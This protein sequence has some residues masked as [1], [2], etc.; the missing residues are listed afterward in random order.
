MGG[1]DLGGLRFATT[2]GND[3][4]SENGEFATFPFSNNK[5]SIT[6]GNENILAIVDTGADINVISKQLLDILPIHLRN[7]FRSQKDKIYC[8]NGS[9]AQVFGKISLPVVISNR[10][11]S[12]Q[13]SVINT[14]MDKVFLGIPF[15]KQYSAQI[16]FNPSNQ[17]T[18]SVHL[19]TPIFSKSFQEI[20]P[21]TEAV[22]QGTLQESLPNSSQGYCYP[23]N[24][25]S[26][27]GYMAAHAAV[28][29]HDDCVPIRVFNSQPYKITINRGERIAS[30]QLFDSDIEL[31]PYENSD[32][33]YDSIN[34]LSNE[35]RVPER[36][37]HTVELN[38]TESKLDESQKQQLQDLVAKYSDCFVNPADGK[39]GLTDLMECKIETVPGT[40]PVCKYPYRLAPHMRDAMGKI[41]KDQVE[42]G[43]I[44]ESTEGAWASPALLVKKSSGDFRLVIDYR[45][46]NA[47]LIPQNLR[48]P[49]IDEVFDTIGENQPQ[50]FSVLDCTQGFHQVPLNTDSRDKTAFIT[51]MGKYRYKT[52]PQ[53]MR[54]A[55]VVFQSLMDLVLRGIQ[56]KYVM[57]YIDDICI[58]SNTFE[59]HLAHLEEVF[60]RLRSANLKLH[61]KKCKFAVQE[62]TYL[63]HVLSPEGIKPNPDKV[64]AIASFPTPTKMKQLRSFLGMIG[65]YRKFI[66]GFGVTA[67]VLYDLT[68]KDVP[69]VWSSECE[70]AFQELKGK[71][72][73]YDV[74]VF[75]NFKKPF[76]LATDASITGLGACLSQEVNGVLRPVGFAGRGLTN[77]ERNYTTTE[78][79]CLAVIWAI[80]HFRVY[81]EGQHFEL[82]TDHNA[83]RFILTNKD[84]R[85]RVARWVTF[86]QQFNYTVKHVKGKNN[87]VP[88]ALSRRDYEFTRTEDDEPIDRYPDLG[89]IHEQSNHNVQKDKLTQVS[90]NPETQ[91]NLYDPKLPIANLCKPGANFGDKDTPV[92]GAIKTKA[93]S[94]VNARREKLR[95]TLTAKA[96][97]N[98]EGIDLS[99]ENIRKE[100]RKDQECRL[101]IKYLTVG[102]LPD[103]DTDARSILLRQEDYIMID[104]ML[105]HIF[106]P[107][108]SKPS[109]QAQLVIPQN[110][111]VHFLKLHHDSELGAHVGNSK[112]L[113][114]MRLKYYWIGMIRDI[115][116]YVLTCPRCQITKSTTGA[117][118]PP[119]QTREVT[120][121]PF[122]TL[123]I[124]TVGPLPKS[125]GY[126]HLVCVTDQY[127]K[128][129]IAW[130]VRDLTATSLIKKFH[131]KIICVYG[132]PRRLVSDNGSA[133]ASS[134]FEELCKLYHI[135][136]SFSTAYHPQSQG[137]VLRGIRNP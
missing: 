132:A 58:F 29:V 53:G 72:L 124:D 108:G 23:T 42:K 44:E 8:A 94:K 16:T 65:Y 117:I 22:I 135:K 123:I 137:S 119:L 69:Y 18:I 85:G 126:E 93:P 106:T 54:N 9:T 116:E 109:A 51:P 121:H 34:S 66:S 67:K 92:W 38:L 48:I 60:T 27:K 25:T 26:G 101:I 64:K 61:P 3:D 113:S 87:V 125:Q 110:L 2:D 136:H 68:K 80:Q 73:S 96:A 33:T 5:L 77:A 62:V 128:Y 105:Y 31:V 129:V 1:V 32:T 90:F 46:L 111:K 37:S 97:E 41:L 20:A 133:F 17:N 6:I 127:S 88:D 86:L 104:G 63:G 100:Q 21:Y 114:I 122:H 12:V 19:A 102:T 131:E 79:E 81:L 78:Q 83:L 130:P 10:K 52:M 89:A 4:D 112:M 14:S 82:H 120:P 74:L 55:P 84:P 50:F 47:A 59:Q 115:R 107:S 43:L 40:T 99:R 45:G 71:M 103:N 98:L 39:L 13:F 15:L 56:F 11:M 70:K 76:H 28:T 75:P 95:P 24:S 7:K 36:P 57:V 49:R 30:F 118:V 35:P 91:T 134:L